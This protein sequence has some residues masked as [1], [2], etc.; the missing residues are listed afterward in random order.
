M[1]TKADRFPKHYFNAAMLKD[2]PLVLV[3]EEETYEPIT[4]RKTGKTTEKSV[5]SFQN[6][7]A[8]LILNA[9]NFDL[10]CEVTGC[11]D[12]ADWPGHEIELFC[13][14]TNMG[15]E[16]VDCVRVRAPGSANPPPKKKLKPAL[17]QLEPEEDDNVTRDVLASEGAATLKAGRRGELDDDIPF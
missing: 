1:A 17:V 13:D 11:T 9:T 10:V 15:S 16:R 7:D 3:I 12:S 5:L 14:R 8:K 4:D 2:N 6:N